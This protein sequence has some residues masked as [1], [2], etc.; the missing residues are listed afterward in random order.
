MKFKSLL[1]LAVISLVIFTN[2]S[3]NTKEETI[4]YDEIDLEKNQSSD[5]D[6]LILV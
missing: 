5:L 1:V 6:S 2:C 3:N 4:Q